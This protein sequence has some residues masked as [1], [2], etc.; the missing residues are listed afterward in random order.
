MYVYVYLYRVRGRR[1]G[2][3][4]PFGANSGTAQ[5]SDTAAAL[6][7]GGGTVVKLGS[8]VC[9]GG[10]G[11]GSGESGAGQ[12]ARRARGPDEY[13]AYAKTRRPTNPDA[14]TARR[15]LPSAGQSPPISR[16]ICVAVAG[17]VT[18][19][20]PGRGAA[21]RPRDSR[22]RTHPRRERATLPTL[23][24]GM[25][26]GGVFNVYLGFF[27]YRYDHLTVRVIRPLRLETAFYSH[28]RTISFC[29]NT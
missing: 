16:L 24:L 15:V 5:R 1:R 7:G 27:F 18:G 23:H 4:G 21:A 25:R 9:G 3:H 20:G 11:G 22:Q 28:F 6:R 29:P 10:G 14:P 12:V 8:S 2:G 26:P 17:Y 19:R 13:A